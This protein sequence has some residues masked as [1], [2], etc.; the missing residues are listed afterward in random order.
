MLDNKIQLSTKE[1]EVFD[2]KRNRKVFGLQSIKN[3]TE[4]QMT[5][6]VESL[7]IESMLCLCPNQCPNHNYHIIDLNGLYTPFAIQ[8]NLIQ[9]SGADELRVFAPRGALLLRGPNSVAIE[10]KLG[11]SSIITFANLTFKSNNGKVGVVFEFCETRQLMLPNVLDCPRSV[12]VDLYAKPY[13][14]RD[15]KGQH[16]EV[17]ETFTTARSISAMCLPHRSVVFG[18]I[19]RKLCDQRR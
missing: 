1:F 5:L 14:S 7:N 12:K 10:S 15:Q 19:K 3:G 6:N 2:G 4:T 9:N 8:T 17:V 18:Q 16:E 11:D 13:P